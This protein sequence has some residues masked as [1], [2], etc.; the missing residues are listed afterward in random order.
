MDYFRFNN[1]FFTEW[2]IQSA[3]QCNLRK[4]IDSFAERKRYM[5][6]SVYFRHWSFCRGI[7]HEID[8]VST[9]E[10]L[11]T[12]R[13][14]VCTRII[15]LLHQATKTH[16][17]ENIFDLWR[18]KANRSCSNRKQ[19]KKTRV[20]V[21]Y[22]ILL[23]SWSN[24]TGGLHYR[25]SLHMKSLVL[26][27]MSDRQ[28]IRDS[29]RR[30]QECLWFQRDHSERMKRIVAFKTRRTI[31]LVWLRWRERICDTILLM[32]KERHIHQAHD[33]YSVRNC[34]RHW[35]YCSLLGKL[36]KK[37]RITLLRLSTRRWLS[38]WF[39]RSKLSSTRS[40]IMRQFHTK[41]LKRLKRRSVL[42][43]KHQHVHTLFRRFQLNQTLQNLAILKLQR[44]I[45]SESQKSEDISMKASESLSRRF[46]HRR[47][48]IYFSSWVE[49]SK[50]FE[51]R[52]SLSLLTYVRFE[53][54][55]LARSHIPVVFGCA[56]LKV[57]W[58]IITNKNIISKWRDFVRQK[59]SC[60]VG[61]LQT[62]KHFHAMR[63]KMEFFKNNSRS[64]SRFKA[65]PLVHGTKFQSVLNSFLFEQHCIMRYR[66]I[67]L[68][69]WKWLTKMKKVFNTFERR[70][71]RNS[72]R[73]R[74]SEWRTKST[75][76]NSLL[77]NQTI[78]LME[79]DKRI[80]I[81]HSISCMQISDNLELFLNQFFSKWRRQSLLLRFYFSLA[82][83][84]FA[85]TSRGPCMKRLYLTRW[86]SYCDGTCCL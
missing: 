42:I 61:F 54:M 34:V 66:M 45:V 36:L 13:A 19:A 32:T 53:S 55:M 30:W 35:E 29:M 85:S 58:T 6:R 27:G 81:C 31:R 86:R 2:R 50:S 60:L 79:C 43:W 75:N 7:V 70:I 4:K 78:S 65:H 33:L 56:F 39:Q 52:I 8:L 12:K 25:K 44:Q 72:T 69:R 23:A 68:E 51:E 67:C 40:T 62:W 48:R 28:M 71:S 21:S 22:H 38:T 49:E 14:D 17:I 80:L 41:K 76:S 9:I 83:V 46:D 63:K 5:S 64:Q 73:R 10:F 26:G 47:K 15:R 77:A 16:V 37:I 82:L 11:T 59:R 1:K 18:Q 20:A 57:K 74:F 3:H 24:W 84:E